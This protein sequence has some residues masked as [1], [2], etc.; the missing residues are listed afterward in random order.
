MDVR[1]VDPEALAARDPSQIALYLRSRGWSPSPA[2]GGTLWQLE[3]LGGEVEALVPANN[4]MKGYAG[5]IRQLLDLLEEVE[6]RSQL[7]IFRDISTAAA[8]VQYVRTMP[9]SPAGTIPINDASQILENIRQWVLAAAVA[10]SSPLRKAVQSAKKPTAALEFMRMVRLGPSYEGSYIW[11][12]EVPLPPRVGQEILPIEQPEIQYQALPFERKVSQFLYTATTKAYSA[13]ELVVRQDEGLD[14]FTSQVDQG[15]TANLCEALAGLAGE[16]ANPFQLT[17]QWAISRPVEP[18][19]PIRFDPPVIQVLSQAAKEMRARTPEEDVRI[20]GSV[21]R[22]HRESNFGAGEVSIAGV[23]EGDSSERLWR[24]WVE[25]SESDYALAISAHNSGDLVSVRGDLSR[26][27]N[28]S[29]IHRVS[30]F[31]Y[32]PEVAP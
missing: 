15:V 19:P 9:N 18:T 14:A 24:V 3:M 13:A 2:A 31:E 32:V 22:L 1:I 27:G 7:E 12:V 5:F 20:I 4:G 16:S 23:M 25:L 17:F 6:Q 30:A 29:T 21:V 10:I 28:R 8:D 11:S 26:R